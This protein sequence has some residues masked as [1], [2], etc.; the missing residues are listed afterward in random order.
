MSE[1]PQGAI[2]P[3]EPPSGVTRDH[4]FISYA[5]E[6]GALAEWLTLRLTAEGYSVWCDRFKLLGGESW[7]NDIDEAIKDRTFRMLQIVSRHSLAKDNPTKE[8]QLA[9]ALQRERKKELFIPLNADG[10]KATELNWQISDIVWVPFE[11]WGV[12]LS[13]LLKKLDRV[14]A[15][16][17]RAIGGL[18]VAARATFPP[19]VVV[20][21]PETLFTN[22]FPFES[23]PAV[24]K[25]FTCEP[26]D[27]EKV[28]G[29]LKT[30]WPYRQVKNSFLSLV[31][32]PDGKEESRL[33][34]ADGGACWANV[35]EID[36]V[37]SEDVLLELLS[38][39]LLAKSLSLGLL[40]AGPTN[41][42]YF[43]RDL[44]VGGKLRFAPPTEVSTRKT[45]VRLWG[46]RRSG[47]T[48]FMHHLGFELKARRGVGK[49][50]VAQIRL[51][52]QVSDDQ[53]NAVSPSLTFRRGAA[54]RRGWFNHQQLMRQHAIMEFLSGGM[55]RVSLS[56]ESGI[57]FALSRSALSF[58]SGSRIDEQAPALAGEDPDFV[59]ADAEGETLPQPRDD[60]AESE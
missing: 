22:W 55:D 8:R 44:V 43:P 15:P 59:H 28:A 46:R 53:G 13:Q 45:H 26:S 6:D 33:L 18:N 21:E 40:Q 16:K 9:L 58:T 17:P 14:K 49:S 29:A 4:L 3:E 37:K 20:D 41:V 42:V 10:T 56:D 5:W 2:A 54:V 39:T 34:R 38:K 35:R 11:D 25:R 48:H 32:P 60:E 30:R 36:G 1:A 51:R 31:K 52:I 50:L 57:E 24:I 27:A 12:G 19:R 23:V 7:P 47:A